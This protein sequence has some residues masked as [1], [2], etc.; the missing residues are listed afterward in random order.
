MQTRG[1]L[2]NKI[3]SE[4]SS[5]AAEDGPAA[6]GKSSDLW[7]RHNGGRRGLPSERQLSTR[8]GPFGSERIFP[9]L[10]EDSGVYGGNLFGLAGLPLNTLP[11]SWPETLRPW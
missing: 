5:A 8:V 3:P 4:P 10:P 11:A 9:L 7:G 2:V 1:S 6:L